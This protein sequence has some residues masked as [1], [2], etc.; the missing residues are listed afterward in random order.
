MALH[1]NV[2]LS[3]KV[4]ATVKAA[5]QLAVCSTLLSRDEIRL[6]PQVDMSP[7]QA[8]ETFKR[9]IDRLIDHS[10]HFFLTKFP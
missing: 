2:A 10:F 5:R 1:C 6:M 9:L 8:L 3:P 7:Y 4:H